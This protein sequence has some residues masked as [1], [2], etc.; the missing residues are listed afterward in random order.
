MIYL[1]HITQPPNSLEQCQ[2]V[3]MNEAQLQKSHNASQSAIANSGLEA[4]YYQH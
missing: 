4:T 3:V 1:S 2:Y